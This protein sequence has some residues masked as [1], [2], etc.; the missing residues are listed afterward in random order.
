MYAIID[1]SGEQVKVEQ[2]QKI[3]VNRIQA[4]EGE[5]IDIDQVLLID[6]EGTVKVGTPVVENAQVSAKV[7]QHKKGEKVKIFKKKRRKGYQVL[8]GHRQALT[9]LQIEAINE[10]G[11]TQEEAS[12]SESGNTQETSTSEGEN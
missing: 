1:I 2:N 9:E 12:T 8:N 4:Q 11:S 3:L 5:Q 6:N 10:N 7:L